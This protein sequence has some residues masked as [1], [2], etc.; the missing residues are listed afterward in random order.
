MESWKNRKNTL[1]LFLLIWSGWVFGFFSISNSKLIPYILP[2]FPPLAMLI[3]NVISK[4]WNQSSENDSS[5]GI[6]SALSIFICLAGCI[7]TFFFSEFLHEKTELFK[8]IHILIGIFFISAL[9]TYY[10]SK[11]Q[12]IAVSIIVASSIMILFTLVYAA[13]HIQRPSV[14][15]LTEIINS[16]R[17][18]NDKIVSFMAYYQDLP[19]YTNQKVIVVEAKGELEFGTTVEDTTSWMIKEEQFIDLWNK[20]QKLWVIGRKT[21]LDHLLNRHPNLKYSIIAEDHGNVLFTQK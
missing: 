14:K 21:E 15:P 18:P 8:Y 13:P 16:N 17:K 4:L 1:Y 2:M 10:Y 5:L 7:M 19:V 20:D 3:G 11:Q 6:Y 9:G 12:K